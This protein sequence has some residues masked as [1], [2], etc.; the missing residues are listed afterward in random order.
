MRE[1]SVLVEARGKAATIEVDDKRI[2]HLTDGLDLHLGEV[3]AGGSVWSARIT[4]EASTPA[5]AVELA[6]SVVEFAARIADM[7]DWPNVR[8]EALR[9][10]ELERQMGESWPNLERRGKAEGLGGDGTSPG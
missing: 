6:V 8:I 7:P 10:D 5:S 2:L 3:S 9:N 1:W 4:V